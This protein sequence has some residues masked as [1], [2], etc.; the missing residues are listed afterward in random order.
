MVN[1]KRSVA[2]LA[3]G[4]T[5]FAGG[6]LVSGPMVGWAQEDQPDEQPAQ[7]EGDEQPPEGGPCRGG[8]RGRHL[9]AAAEAIGIE[10]D[11]LREAL[12]DDQTIAQVA[13][14]N[15]VEVQ[16]VVD[17]LVA[18]AN[19]HL[20]EA[21]ANGRLTQE[22]ADEKKANLSE[23]ITALVNGERP[24]GARPRPDEDGD[25]EEQTENTSS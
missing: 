7:G 10:P 1:L 8:P 5:A 15:G 18:D 3:L 4:A 14:A 24:E 20:D 16:A 13:E 19:E 12:R 17:A 22:E 6:A 23:R 11:A 9:E 21:V 2:G 25:Q